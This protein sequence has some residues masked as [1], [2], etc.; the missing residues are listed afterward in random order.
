MSYVQEVIAV[1]ETVLEYQWIDVPTGDDAP[2]PATE[3]QVQLVFT[4]MAGMDI[5]IEYKTFERDHICS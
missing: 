5:Y 2:I 3:Y 4:D 1:K